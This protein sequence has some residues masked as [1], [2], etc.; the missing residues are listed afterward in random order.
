MPVKIIAATLDDKQLT[1]YK[2][3][4]SILILPQGSPAIKDITTDAVKQISEK[5]YFDYDESAYTKQAESTTFQ[6]F[7]KK[8]SGLVR[9]FKI[10]KEKVKQI[11]S[12]HLE[13]M[14][15]GEI[16]K[17]QSEVNK[18]NE[19]V[20]DEIVANATPVTTI[21]KQS[22]VHIQRSTVSGNETPKD[23]VDRKSDEDD[24]QKKATDTI[25]AVTAEGVVIPNVENIESQFAYANTSGNPSAMVNFLNRL[26]GVNQARIKQ[27]L[28]FLERAELPIA[29][30]GTIVAYKALREIAGSDKPPYKELDHKDDYTGR[31]FQGVG[32]FV[33]MDI[34]LVDQNQNNECSKG[35]HIARRGYLRSFNATEIFLV[36]VKPED[37]VA[38]PAYDSNKIRVKG[39][40]L[41]EK[42]S[43][44]TA[45]MVRNNSKFTDTDEAKALLGKILKGQ[46]IGITHMVQITEDR[47]MGLKVTPTELAKA[48]VVTEDFTEEAKAEAIEVMRDD[49]ESPPV[50]PET[51]VAATP[52]KPKRSDIANAIYVRLLAAST[53]EEF[54]VIKEEL[55][56]YKKA[57][58]CTFKELGIPILKIDDIQPPVPAAP[59]KEAKP[60]V[61][62]PKVVK[63]SKK[64]E[65]VAKA[66]Q[67]KPAG[68]KAEMLAL[69]P[70]KDKASAEILMD[71]K[72]KAKKSWAALGVNDENVARIT[73]LLG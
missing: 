58:K 47:G 32:S 27:L 18:V 72:K 62:K 3:D 19:K 35:L 23:V 8:S 15:V 50:A 51:V 68:T 41:L 5:G 55:Q 65:K 48:P 46:H 22:N 67:S 4:A 33:F 6:D 52:A 70:V 12:T 25:V 21:T 28:R 45:R 43:E 71:W 53:L 38:L 44:Q 24:E 11:F 26:K 36:K 16:P 2:E 17:P 60:K 64:A 63:P 42:L 57:C 1:L 66:T 7:E 59:K 61:Q 40:H 39:Y 13:P 73:K 54:T 31:V 10:A 29:D 49:I 14:S 56:A 69:L 30:D 34:S 9:F 20:I 37:V